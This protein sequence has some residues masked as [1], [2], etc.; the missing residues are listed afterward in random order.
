MVKAPIFSILDTVS[1]AN[2]KETHPIK[3]MLSEIE[4]FIANIDRYTDMDDEDIQEIRHLLV[5]WKMREENKEE[6]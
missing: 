2:L 6:E 3:N 4:D 1:L 5:E